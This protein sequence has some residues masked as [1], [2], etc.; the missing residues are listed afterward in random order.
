MKRWQAYVL[1]LTGMGLFILFLI[2][3]SEKETPA[4]KR[5][6]TKYIEPLVQAELNGV[7]VDVSRANFDFDNF[8]DL[9]RMLQFDYLDIRTNARGR[10]HTRNT[11]PIQVGDTIRKRAGENQFSLTRRGKSGSYVSDRIDLKK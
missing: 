9:S 8:T 10:L 4:G 3:Q 11:E 2:W 5:S 6:H 7:V 1:L